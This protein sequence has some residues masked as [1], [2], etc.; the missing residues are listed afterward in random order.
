LRGRALGLY[1]F[2]TSITVLLASLI[3]GELWKHFGPRLP[4]YVSAAL[5][6]AAAAM[7]S[8]IGRKRE[9]RAA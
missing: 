8:L 3:T 6:L 1:F 5:A 4:F 9:T 7:L 2:V